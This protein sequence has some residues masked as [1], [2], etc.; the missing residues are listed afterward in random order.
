ME[1]SERRIEVRGMTCAHCVRAVTAAA[2]GIAGVS[3]PQ[4]ELAT[5]ILSWHGNADR[6][7]I[8]AALARAGYEVVE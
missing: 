4:A 7:A 8:R 5:G 6:S 2:G 1:S 3:R